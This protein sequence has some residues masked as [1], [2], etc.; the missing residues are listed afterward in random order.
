MEA[1]WT[2]LVVSNPI[3]WILALLVFSFIVWAVEWERGFVATLLLA[4][5]CTLFYFF[6]SGK[7]V[8]SWALEN[9]RDLLWRV[10]AYIACGVVWAT[11]YWI[12]HCFK[13]K[14]E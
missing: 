14:H 11:A 13:R 1:V 9:P 8:A 3:C 10:V 2:L 6:G 4:G 5:F 12:I 7:E